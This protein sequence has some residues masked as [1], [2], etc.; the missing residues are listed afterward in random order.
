M[1]WRTARLRPGRWCCGW[2]GAEFEGDVS[3]SGLNQALFPLVG[4]FGELDAALREVHREVDPHVIENVTASAMYADRLAEVREP[5]W[6]TVQR[7]RDGGP[8]RKQDNRA[9]EPV[10]RR[11]LHRQL[12]RSRGARGRRAPGQRGTGRPLLRLV[13]PVPAG[14]AGRGSGPVR[15]EPDA[16]QSGH[17]VG[18]AARCPGGA[19]LDVA[20]AGARRPRRP[21]APGCRPARPAPWP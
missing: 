17:R 16:G 21:G 2:P 15:H 8:A 9:G 20:R 18:R 7:G 12:G 11:L 3:F 14:A 6:R 19:G 5:L 4:E 13:L 10:L 1:S